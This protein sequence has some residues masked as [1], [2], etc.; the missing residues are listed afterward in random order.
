MAQTLFSRMLRDLDEQEPETVFERVREGVAACCEPDVFQGVVPQ[1]R[2]AS[3]GHVDLALNLLPFLS[4]LSGAA[5]T[6]LVAPLM[7]RFFRDGDQSQFGLGNAITAV[8]RDTED[9]DLR[10]NLEEF[11][12]GVLIGA[13]P[14][15]PIGRG[16]AVAARS[17]W[18][19]AIV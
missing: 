11:G 19:A 3:D 13:A 6:Q 18:A 5:G 8:A 2:T 4:R 7:E 1:M 16:G 10:W 17:D 9:P 15:Y 12:G 14:R